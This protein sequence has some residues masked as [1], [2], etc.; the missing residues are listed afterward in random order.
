MNKSIT[1]GKEIME[2]KTYDN[3]NKYISEKNLILEMEKRVEPYLKSIAESGTIA[4]KNNIK[5]YYEKYVVKNS[6]GN[7]VISHGF[8][9]FIEKYNE[10]IYYFLQENY[11]VYIIEHRGNSRSQRLGKDDSQINVENFNYY[12]EDFKKFLDEVVK[13]DSIEK[14]TFLFGHSMGGGIGT[15]FLEKY[16]N[17]FDKAVFSSPMYE[18]NSGKTPK[19]I[20]IFICILMNMFGKSKEYIPG[21]KEYTGERKFPN[22]TTSSENRYNYQYNKI[23]NNKFYQTGGASAK[24]YLESLI[25]TKRLRAK[26][27]AKK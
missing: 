9:E 21:Q 24:W 13:K 8:G 23:K 5:L 10:L 2:L 26:K 11:S 17:Y 22:R 18:I 16:P 25:A 15:I 1:N 20:A 27:N 6:K 4:G 14:Q 7:I 19:I 3:L 12:I